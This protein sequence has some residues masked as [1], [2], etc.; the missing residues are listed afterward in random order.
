[1]LTGS[2]GMNF[3]ICLLFGASMSNMWQLLNILQIITMLPLL[4]IPFSP[5]F[6]LLSQTLS[7]LAQFDIFPE[8][9]SLKNLRESI[10][11]GNVFGS[12]I[13]YDNSEED[14]SRNSTSGNSTRRI[15]IVQ[16]KESLK[17]IKVADVSKIGIESYSVLENLGT[18]GDIMIYTVFLSIIILPLQCFRNSCSM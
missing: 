18:L 8:F 11:G 1:M 13:S 6:I 10:I 2:I 14:S 15:L 17:T 9:L 4:N 16:Q 3:I 7:S 12:L 5:S